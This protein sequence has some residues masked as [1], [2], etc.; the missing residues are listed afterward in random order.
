[1]L[2]K[3]DIAKAVVILSLDVMPQFYD[4]IGMTQYK[5]EIHQLF[6]HIVRTVNK[7]MMFQ[8][9]M[10]EEYYGY[11]T[12][13]AIFQMLA[14]ETNKLPEAQAKF[15]RDWMWNAYGGQYCSDI[16]FTVWSDV[17]LKWSVRGFTHQGYSEAEYGL[18]N[19][20]IKE[21][22]EVYNRDE[23]L[24][25]TDDFVEQ[26]H[27]LSDYDR[28]VHRLYG[29]N[30]DDDLHD[31]FLSPYFYHE[32]YKIRQ[33]VKESEIL[34]HPDFPFEKLYQAALEEM[35]MLNRWGKLSDIR[36]IK[37]FRR[38]E[39]QCPPSEYCL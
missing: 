19:A 20:F 24:N 10:V 9:R 15:L 8:N 39:Y 28:E 17:L 29:Y 37:E 1:M 34:R 6:Q 26:N 12:Q 11:G 18:I 3:R 23:F 13:E 25:A 31:P 32:G 16:S 14:R 27:K 21:Y 4:Y 5:E 2:D 35:S 36:T 33:L 22:G 38:E 30:Y 7:D